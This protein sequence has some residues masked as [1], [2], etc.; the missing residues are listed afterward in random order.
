MATG[1]D[2]VVLKLLPGQTQRVTWDFRDCT[3]LLQN[4]TLLVSQPRSKNGRQATL[5]A[6]TPLACV[7]TN[8]TTGEVFTAAP[9]FVLYL[10]TL[11]KCQ[12]VLDLT[13]SGTKSLAV[14]VSWTGSMA[15]TA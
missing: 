6:G 3:C 13:Y 7:A 12:L 2:P 8:L 11:S 5:A 14:E 15:G 10:G 9:N 1:I 4:F